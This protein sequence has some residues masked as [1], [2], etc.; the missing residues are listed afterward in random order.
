MGVITVY[1]NG[2]FNHNINAQNYT[3][4]IVKITLPSTFAL[5]INSC[6]FINNKKYFCITN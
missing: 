1:M 4:N 2:T 3:Y 5:N 6:S